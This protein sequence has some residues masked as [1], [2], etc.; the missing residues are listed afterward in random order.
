MQSQ[1]GMKSIRNAANLDEKKDIRDLAN[2]DV[3]VLISKH[4]NYTALQTCSNNLEVLLC[5]KTD[6][7]SYGCINSYYSYY[8]FNKIIIIT[9]NTAFFFSS[10]CVPG[11]CGDPLL[12]PLRLCLLLPQPEHRDQPGCGY[13]LKTSKENRQCVSTLSAQD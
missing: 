5:V 13:G 3:T 6:K 1:T 4:N 10:G 2:I 8:L 9:L 11:H 7:G 12:R